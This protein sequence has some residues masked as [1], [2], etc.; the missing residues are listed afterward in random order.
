M[1]VRV[2]RLTPSWL[3][4]G[5][6]HYAGWMQNSAGFKAEIVADDDE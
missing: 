3:R 1:V 5:P 6:Q 2:R 4:R